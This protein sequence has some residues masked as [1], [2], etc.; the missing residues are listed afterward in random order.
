MKKF[1]KIVLKTAAIASIVA[2]VYTS[3]KNRKKS[4]EEEI[5]EDDFETIMDDA[6]DDVDKEQVPSN[7][8]DDKEET[9]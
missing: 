6:W 9:T 8:E 1:T 2:I 7:L 4:M 5:F 3:I